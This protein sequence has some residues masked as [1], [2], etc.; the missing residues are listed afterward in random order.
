V[1][2]L[3]QQISLASLSN[4]VAYQ[5][6]LKLVIEHGYAVS[7]G[8][9]QESTYKDGY[10][11]ESSASRRAAIITFSIFVP[12]TAESATLQASTTFTKQTLE[13]E[14]NNAKTAL[15]NSGAISTSPTLPTAS[16]MVVE[17]PVLVHSA[18]SPTAAPT[19]AAVTIPVFYLLI[20]GVACFIFLCVTT[21]VALRRN[22]HYQKEADN[23]RSVKME[24]MEAMQ[25]E[26]LDID[27]DSHETK[28]AERRKNRTQ[29]KKRSEAGDKVTVSTISTMSMGT[30]QGLKIELE[31]V[32]DYEYTKNV[33]TEMM[34]KIDAILPGLYKQYDVDNS[35][36]LNSLSELM[37]LTVN[38]TFHLGLPLKPADL[39]RI[40]ELVNEVGV[41]DWTIQEFRKCYS[42]TIL[43]Y[44]RWS[45][46]LAGRY[47]TRDVQ[48]LRKLR[49]P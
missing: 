45:N 40:K 31:Q 20:G 18:I 37:Q 16:D 35:G 23:D 49:I 41:N 15:S 6:D 36:T 22:D 44:M 5:G 47:H 8:I 13:N 3:T 21:C 39:G 9:M 48:P 2:K 34:K 10:S 42:N 25:S 32:N 11:L 30:I 17:T 28:K 26:D 7:I 46:I 4:S 43:D 38:L 19:V 1:S 27:V 12:P 29:S 33:N 24:V 14:M